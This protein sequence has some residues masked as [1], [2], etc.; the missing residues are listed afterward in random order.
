MPDSTNRDEYWFQT[1]GRVLSVLLARSAYSGMTRVQY[2]DFFRTAVT[3][4]LGPLP[5]EYTSSPVSLMCS[6]HTPVEICW[7]FKSTGEISVQYAVDALC[8]T[9]GTPVSP[10]QN[11]LILQWLAITGQCQGFDLT[12]TR[13][14]IKSLLWPS[15]S[16]P[17]DLQRVS[18]FFIGNC[19]RSVLGLKSP[20]TF[21]QALA[22]PVPE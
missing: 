6:D 14:C 2:D 1:I 10:K 22:S 7:A 9:H 13:K 4:L 11:L 15:N 21:T 8:P 3:P 16:L 19:P 12:L 20:L 18:Q 17:Q 5:H